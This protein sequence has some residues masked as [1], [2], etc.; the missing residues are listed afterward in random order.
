MRRDKKTPESRRST[1]GYLES[2]RLG[3]DGWQASLE[4]RSR[5]YG[6]DKAPWL[7][8]WQLLIF[9]DAARLRIQNPQPDQISRFELASAGLGVRFAAR[10]NMKGVLDWAQALKDSA[11][12]NAGDNRAHLRLEY[13]F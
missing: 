11:A 10:K 1:R 12:T 2:E 4:W 13:G 6:W 9:T 7:Q 5:T 3:D 8:Q